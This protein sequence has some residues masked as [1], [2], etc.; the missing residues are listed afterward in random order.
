MTQEGVGGLQDAP[1]TGLLMQVQLNIR[2][3]PGQRQVFTIERANARMRLKVLIV[4]A[5]TKPL[6][7]LE[8]SEPDPLTLN[9]SLMRS[10]FFTSGLGGLRIHHVGFLST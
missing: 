8:S 2:A 5:W 6:S 7:P 10:L 1:D 9:F 4:T 3:G